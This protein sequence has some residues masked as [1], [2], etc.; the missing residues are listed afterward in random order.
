MP[1]S[2]PPDALRT[3]P[4]R[5][6]PATM[7]K[8]PKTSPASLRRLPAQISDTDTATP[9]QSSAVPNVEIP[10]DFPPLSILDYPPPED[11]KTRL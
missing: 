5:I 10:V 3:S 7:I 2:D 8:R 6:C 1:G 9:A 11:G 4:P